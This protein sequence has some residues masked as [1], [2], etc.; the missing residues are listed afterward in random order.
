MFYSDFLYIGNV[1]SNYHITAKKLHFPPFCVI[2]SNLS[3]RYSRK[4]AL[5]KNCV[6]I[7][8]I[9]LMEIANILAKVRNNDLMMVCM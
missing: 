8:V 7:Y 5:K 4:Y 9:A 2:V 1:K 6:E 3:R